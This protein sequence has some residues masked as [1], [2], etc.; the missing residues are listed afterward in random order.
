MRILILDT[1][2]RVRETLRHLFEAELGAQVANGAN[3]D[4]A[5]RTLATQPVDA[6]VAAEGYAVEALSPFA[7]VIV[8]GVGERGLWE[9]VHVAAGAVGYWP[10]D[11]ELDELLALVRAAGLVERAD[12]AYAA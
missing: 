5:T 7:P 1:S 6:V 12:R 2:E 3:P 4:F 8:I 11:G 10:K 9:E